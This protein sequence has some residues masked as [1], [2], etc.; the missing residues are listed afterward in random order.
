M[1]SA[2]HAP[3]PGKGQTFPPTASPHSLLRV[4]VAP[5]PPSTQLG[6]HKD[7]IPPPGRRGFRYQ[8]GYSGR[9]IIIKGF[10]SP[11][12]YHLLTHGRDPM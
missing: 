2:F 5:P 12:V 3:P 4:G 7:N 10:T 9:I 1:T 6:E 11:V 8:R